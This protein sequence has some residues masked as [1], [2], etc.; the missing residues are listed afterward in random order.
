MTKKRLRS[1][2][3]A[4]TLS[5]NALRSLVAGLVDQVT[6]LSAEV[7]ELRIENAARREEN[8]EL[9]LENTRLKVDNQLLRDEIARIRTCRH[10]RPFARPAWRRQRM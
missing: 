9:R 4:D 1:S 5:L 6:A 3:H 10:A 8:A 2:E 7:K